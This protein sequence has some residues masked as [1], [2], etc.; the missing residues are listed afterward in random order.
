MTNESAILG[1]LARQEQTIAALQA[2]NEA[3]RQALAALTDKT[4]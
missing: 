2:E 1:L 3:L 4:D